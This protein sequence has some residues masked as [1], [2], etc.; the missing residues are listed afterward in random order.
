MARSGSRRARWVPLAWAAAG[1][2]LLVVMLVWEGDVPEAYGSFRGFLRAHFGPLGVAGALLLLYLEE[3]G[4]PLPLPGD[5][6]LI[7][8]GRQAAG[9]AAVF[10]AE[11][12]AVVAVVV[13]GSSNLFW[14]SRRWG[15]RLVG[16][17]LSG[18]F[19]LNPDR[20]A[21]AEGWFRRWGLVAVIFGRHLPGFRIPI[22][23]VAGTFGMPY[24]RFAPSVAVSAVPWAFFWLWLGRTYG[25][26]AGRYVAG[27]PWL[28]WL[29]TAVVV[30]ALGYFAVRI[31]RALAR[32]D[33][34]A[35]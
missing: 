10:V 13:A 8:L 11:W 22:T 14:V 21:R 30:L 15:R 17:R 1:V 28:Y 23:V 35:A 12:A 7:F 24:R 16:H 20:I 5:A 34:R 31:V 9:S 33:R 3:S 6:L 27:H 2:L 18:A 19:H 4:L 25:R 32:D 29:G 26:A